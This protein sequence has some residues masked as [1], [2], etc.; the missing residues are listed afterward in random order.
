MGQK[1]KTPAIWKNENCC[2]NA[3]P[4]G[5]CAVISE[6]SAAGSAVNQPINLKPSFA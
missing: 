6:I 4:N 1:E 5:F 3:R 2:E